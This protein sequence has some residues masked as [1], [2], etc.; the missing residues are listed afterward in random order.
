MNKSKSESHSSDESSVKNKLESSGDIN[1]TSSEGSVL[2]EGTDIKTEKDLNLKADK[3]IIVQSS[4]DEYNY[5][6]KS[7]SSGINAD[8][9]ISTDPSGI[10]GGVTVSQNK[11]KGKG[12]GTTN[13]NSKFEVGGTHRAEA[14]ETVKYEGANV[15][16][17]RVEIKGEEVIISSSKD[18]GISKSE[19]KG[20]SIKFTPLP[21][22]LNVNYNKGKGEKDWVSD[23]TSIIAKEGGIIESKDFTNS[24][25]V[26]GSESEE[27]KLIVKADNVTVEHLKD[28]D[29]NKVSGGGINIKGTGIPDVSIITGGQDKRQDTNATAVNTEFV[30]KGEEKTAEELGFNTDINKAQEITKDEDRVLDVDLH[31]DLLNKEERDKIAQAGEK[32]GDLAEAII[33]SNDGGIFNTYKENRYGNLLNDYIKKSGVS[34]LFLDEKISLEDKR[35]ALTDLV[36]GF[37]KDRKYTGPMPEI[38]I[39]EKSFAV[40]SS[41]GYGTEDGKNGKEIIFISQDSL[42]SPDVLQKLGHEL[43]HLV[44]Y[45]KDEKTAENIGS[46]IEDIKP[47]EEKDYN[48]YLASIKDKYKDLPSL[49]ESKELESKIPDEYKEKLVGTII[50]FVFSPQTAGAPDIVEVNNLENKNGQLYY[51]GNKV[52]VLDEMKDGKIVVTPIPKDFIVEQIEGAVVGEAA[53]AILKI[54]GKY[55]LSTPAGKYVVSKSGKVIGKLSDL[56]KSTS[57]EVAEGTTEKVVKKE[58]GNVVEHI[59]KDQSEKGFKEIVSDKNLLKESIESGKIK[60]LYNKKWSIDEI[61]NLPYGKQTSNREILGN[62]TDAKKFFDSQVLPETIKTAPN[63]TIL[64]KNKDG[65]IFS[66]R[67]VSSPYS[68]YVPTITID[69]IKGLKKIKFIEKVEDFTWKKKK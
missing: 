33:N 34:G 22:E 41:K 66:Y 69:G 8:L 37:L 61:K 15:E 18:T 14:G 45:D 57:K 4:K 13:V 48:E 52:I 23:Q 63:G 16:A 29:T 10:L 1:I 12:E 64:G 32:I 17:G 49:E 60:E 28:K 19:N 46:K 24:G 31:T 55:V 53:G 3:D 59:V 42:N 38:H 27:N 58:T 40:D 47:E 9:S 43:G 25:A 11:G 30:V 65:I 51:N 54:G 44:K 5:S 2:I 7:S 6:S 68:E 35:M 21:S 56:V 26:I 39:G 50:D 62:A 20:G 67:A 36:E